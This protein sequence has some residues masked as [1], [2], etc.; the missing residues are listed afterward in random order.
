M[1]AFTYMINITIYENLHKKHIFR[2]IQCVDICDNPYLCMFSDVQ[3]KRVNIYRNVNLSG[4]KNC[5]R[6]FE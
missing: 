1:F 3:V 6:W 2:N 4:H 5:R